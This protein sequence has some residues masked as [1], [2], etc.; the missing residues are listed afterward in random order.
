MSVDTWECGFIDPALAIDITLQQPI[1]G[2][3][4]LRPIIKLASQGHWPVAAHKMG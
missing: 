4:H 1:E 3:C 2:S